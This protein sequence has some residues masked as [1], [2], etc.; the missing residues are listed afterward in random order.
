MSGCHK[1]SQYT[2][3]S[4]LWSI[5]KINSVIPA[6]IRT[7]HRLADRPVTLPTEPAFRK[8][9]TD[10]GKWPAPQQGRK[11]KHQHPLNWSLEGAENQSLMGFEP[12]SLVV[13]LAFFTIYRARNSGSRKLDTLQQIL[14]SI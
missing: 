7:S 11:K 12:Q 6:G 5:E 9:D 14:N 1:N 13:R 2:L 4:R 3:N 10:R 8:L